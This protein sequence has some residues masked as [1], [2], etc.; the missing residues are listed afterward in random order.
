LVYTLTDADKFIVNA[1]CFTS[2]LLVFTKTDIHKVV[3]TGSDFKTYA[4]TTEALLSFTWNW[5]WF[6]SNESYDLP[7]YN[8][9]DTLLYFWAGNK[10]FSVWNTLAA[11][12]TSDTFRK[13]TKIIWFTFLNSS[14]KIYINYLNVSS[15]LKFWTETQS[16]S[17]EYYNRIFKAVTTDWQIDYVVCTDWLWLYN[18]VN[19]TKLFDYN[20][21]DFGKTWS[22]YVP[23]QN[24]I[25]L[26]PHFVY[27]AYNKNIIKRWKK[28]T[29]LAY[30]FSIS[31]VE[32]NNLTAISDKMTNAW[33]LYYASDDKKWYYQS[34]TYKTTWYIE[35]VIF[36]GE[37]MEKF[38]KMDRI[39][40]AI[41]VLTWCSIDVYFSVNWATYP[42]TAN[43]SI[44]PQTEKFKEL[45]ANELWWLDY[46]WIKAKIVINWNGTIS[47]K[48]Y[49]F[50]TISEYQKNI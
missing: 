5:Q 38:K 13:W 45:F 22:I 44:A 20:F 50:T 19:W 25:S 10:L 15:E 46:Y 27:I 29:N 1:I 43:F 40:N 48:L 34:T 12:S 41:E 4:S 23:P 6:S 2:F 7:V 14:L 31:A 18:G 37:T 16:D 30:W 24:L 47:P 26:D 35:L 17:I 8:Y 39:F 32:A 49:E 33:T 28:F 11:V 21:V 3:F 9:K 42:W 36:F